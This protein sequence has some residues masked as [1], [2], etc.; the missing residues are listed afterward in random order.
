MTDSISESTLTVQGLTPYAQIPRWILRAG[1]NLSH[2]AVRLYGV[3]MTYADNDTRTAFPGRERLAEDMGIKP[4]TI[5]TYVKELEAYG[6]LIVDR[7]RNKRTGNYYANHYTLV[8]D[9]PGANNSTRQSAEI[10]SISKPTTLTTPTSFTSDQRS[11]QSVAPAL[12]KRGQDDSRDK[13]K[14]SDPISPEFYESEDRKAL[15]TNVQYLAQYRK[16]TS[17]Q[18]KQTDDPDQLAK[19][20]LNFENITSQ[21][22]ENL[23]TAFPGIDDYQVDS[24]IWDYGWEPPMKAATDRFTAAKWFNQFINSLQQETGSLEWRGHNA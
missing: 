15:I 19:I 2:G 6:A 12:S 13:A 17:E 8:F 9:H 4:R 7:R 23:I 3:I 20:S 21:F 24:M 11:E 10:C 14:Q 5:T 22:T 16:Q 18:Y 1:D